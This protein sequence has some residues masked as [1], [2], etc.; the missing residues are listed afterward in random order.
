MLPDDGR[1]NRIILAVLILLSVIMLTLYFRYGKDSVLFQ[2]RRATLYIVSPIQSVASYVIDPFQSGWENISEVSSLRRKNVLLKEDVSRLQ[3]EITDLERAKRENERLRELLEFKKDYSYQT[4]PAIVIGRSI[5]PW[6]TNIVINKGSADG[7]KENSPVVVN[8]GL[9]G[10]IVEL[11]SHASQVQLITDQKSGVA[12]QI[13]KTSESGILQGK[14]GKELE[15][16]FISRDAKVKKGN[17][18]I[19]SG[20]GGVFPK[21]I[22]LGRISSVRQEPYSLYKQIKVK[23]RIDFSKLEEVLVITNPHDKT[24]FKSTEKEM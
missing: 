9:V 20:L 13:L 10:Q 23:S 15:L 18:V 3:K 5:T 17:K 12:A 6:E 1:R 7:V 4:E 2:F 21:G 22:Y 8:D 14:M 24:P 11:T 19:T 16:D